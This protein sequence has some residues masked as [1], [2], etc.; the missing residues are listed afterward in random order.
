[1]SQA[2]TKEANYFPESLLKTSTNPKIPWPDIPS[3]QLIELKK[4]NFGSRR[5]RAKVHNSQKAPASTLVYKPEHNKKHKQKKWTFLIY[6][7]ADNDLYSFA[8][9][10]IRQLESI[11]SNDRINILLHLDIH[12]P[13]QKKITKHLYIKKNKLVQVGPDRAMDSGDPMTLIDFF[14]W[15]FENY[16]SEFMC[17]DFWNHGTGPISPTHQRTINPSEL[18]YFN[19]TTKLIELDRR[20]GFMDFISSM[21]DRPRNDR[22]ICFDETTGNFLTDTS[23]AYALNV[24]C[25]MRKKPIDLIYFDACLMGS[26]E[27]AFM[28]SD[29]AHYCVGSEE[30]V[31]GTGADYSQVLEPFI[32]ACP[33]PEELSRHIVYAYEKT[34]GSLT[35]DY[36]Q[37]AILL[38]PLKKLNDHIHTIAQLLI[39][40]LAKQKNGSVKEMIR[41]S[42]HK[43]FCPTFD[44]PSYTD[45]GCFFANAIKNCERCILQKPEETAIFIDKLKS[46]L[47]ES[48]D[49]L[50]K[51]VIANCVGKNLRKARGLSIYFPERKIHPSYQQ[52]KFANSNKWIAFL[53]RYLGV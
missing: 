14:K 18:F 35:N 50:D 20:I 10:N 4:D 49:C 17:L 27:V 15:G 6:M 47:Q 45:A 34:Y 43:S 11:G 16:P 30:V 23:L 3:E 38:A 13:G 5:A 26:T 53:S 25:Q 19:P 24:M 40:G 2:N 32:S 52:T 21:A 28:L 46:E 1:M 9:R 41:S 12:L 36:T 48:L 8:G 42:R 51:A 33:T 7:A 37:S 22:A 29:Y 44:E 39:E 31:L